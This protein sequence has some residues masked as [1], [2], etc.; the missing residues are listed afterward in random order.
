MLILLLNIAHSILKK[1][2][3]YFIRICYTI[4][5]L[6]ISQ[7][8]LMCYLGQSEIVIMFSFAI[9]SRKEHELNAYFLQFGRMHIPYL[10]SR[11]NFQQV[12][13]FEHTSCVYTHT[14]EVP[15]EHFFNSFQI[16]LI[17]AFFLFPDTQ[18][19]TQ[20]GRCRQERE[21]ERW[22]LDMSSNLGLFSL[23]H[24]R[25]KRVAYG[26]AYVQSRRSCGWWRVPQY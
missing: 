8:K 25:L 10:E 17:K 1:R 3:K 12:I 9:K 21:G 18:A 22:K 4:L 6:H 16:L 13:K 7:L 24:Q 5:L 23:C 26:G 2:N 20:T 19:R 14:H 11:Q 15:T